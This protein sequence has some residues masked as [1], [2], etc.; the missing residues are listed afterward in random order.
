MGA[1]FGP[2]P[3]RGP[4][5]APHPSGPPPSAGSND[6]AGL[7]HVRKGRHDDLR[8]DRR[9]LDDQRTPSTTRSDDLPASWSARCR[10]REEVTLERDRSPMLV[11]AR[12]M[13]GPPSR[14]RNSRSRC[15]RA[16][17]GRHRGRRGGAGA[18]G[19]G[20]GHRA[21]RPSAPRSARSRSRWTPAVSTVLAPAGHVRR[22][23]SRCRRIWP[24]GS[25]SCIDTF[26]GR[27]STSSVRHA[28]EHHESPRRLARRSV[29]VAG[30]TSHIRSCPRRSR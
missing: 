15:T 13:T 6:P 20:G 3:P 11:A 4:P 1:L 8:N 16:P 7:P 27:A 21:A 17:G 18:P 30:N 29:E 22:V 25:S 26:T 28:V 19:Q 9:R 10:L 5:A 2:T 12:R 24:G 23:E 14:R